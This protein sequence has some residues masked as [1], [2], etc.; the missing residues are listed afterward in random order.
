MMT[1]KVKFLIPKTASLETEKQIIITHHK[2]ILFTQPSNITG[3]TPCSQEEA[4]T[5]IFLHILDTANH[6]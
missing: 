3:H 5:R 2:D 1:I 6:G 4:D